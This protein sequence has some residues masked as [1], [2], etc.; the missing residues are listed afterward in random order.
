M[1]R[2]FLIDGIGALVSAVMLGLVL[3]VWAP[4]FGM[5]RRV[6][7]PLALVAAGF[8]IY[9]LTCSVRTHDPKFLFAI[10]VANTFGEGA[11]DKDG[12]YTN[13]SAEICARIT[14]LLVP[15]DPIALS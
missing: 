12:N 4:V 13:A 14:A 3:T 7:I 9:S 10:A 5:P 15:D 8:A 1:R 6:L 11:F 2:L